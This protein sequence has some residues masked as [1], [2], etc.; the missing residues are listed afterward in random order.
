MC[1]SSVCDVNQRRVLGTVRSCF[2]KFVAVFLILKRQL[3][4]PTPV[5]SAGLCLK[6]SDEGKTEAVLFCLLY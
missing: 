6:P 4:K 3:H 2:K 1:C 5:F